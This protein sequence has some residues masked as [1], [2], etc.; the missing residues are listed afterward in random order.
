M[1]A[2][3]HGSV[4]EVW[5]DREPFPAPPWPDWSIRRLVDVPFAISR[6]A[7]LDRRVTVPHGS[8]VISRDGSAGTEERRRDGVVHLRCWQRPVPV[9][10]VMAPWSATRTE[11]RLQ[12]GR[13]LT[14]LHLPPHYFDVA[15][16]V[17]D[18]ICAAIEAQAPIA[19]RTSTRT[20]RHLRL[21]HSV[22]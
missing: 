6:T 21:V 18:E 9:E 22:D 3:G 4:T 2:E 19:A 20:K 1:V 12:L 10:L 7:P 11:V 5:P 17:T 15:H 14:S 16:A 13:E 8:L